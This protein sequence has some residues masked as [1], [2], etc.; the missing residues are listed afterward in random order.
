MK[1]H[2]K[3]E[4]RGTRALSRWRM[5]ADKAQNRILAHDRKSKQNADEERTRRS[6][7][8]GLKKREG[9]AKMK[10]ARAGLPIFDKPLPRAK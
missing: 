5:K 4:K 2:E 3:R 9:G 7:C 8:M 1:M 10:F 6:M